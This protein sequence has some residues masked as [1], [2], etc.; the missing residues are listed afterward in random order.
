MRWL[1]VL[2]IAGMYFIVTSTQSLAVSPVSFPRSRAFGGE[3]IRISVSE[4]GEQGNGIS[5]RAQLSA[6]GRWVA[7]SSNSFNLTDED[8]SPVE[9]IFVHDLDT[10][11]LEILSTVAAGESQDGDST[12][13]RVS[14]DGGAVVWESAAGNL[15]AN[16]TNEARDIFLRQT[17]GAILRLSINGEGEEGNGESLSPDISA[18]GTV[19]VFESAADN[20]VPND[21][22]GVKDIFVV[23]LV[24]EGERAESTDL[25]SPF[26]F[27]EVLRISLSTNG[28][29]AD[30]DSSEARLS[31]DGRFVLFASAATNLVAEDTNGVTDIFV[32]EI[33]TGVTERVSVASDGAQADGHSSSGVMSADGRYVLFASFAD[34]F[35]TADSP[36]QDVFRYD[37]VTGMTELVSIS[38]LGA[39]NA[40]AMHPSVSAD[41]H[42]IVFASL[43]NNLVPNDTNGMYD[44]FYKDMRTGVVIRLSESADGTEGNR[45][46]LAPT[47]S[48]N[49]QIVAFGSEA[50]NLVAG[51]TNGLPDIFVVDVE[52]SLPPTLYLPFVG[53]S[54]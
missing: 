46:S 15:V 2:L 43:A 4:T 22:N 48:S 38:P 21:T 23:N 11:A 9:D 12:L 26:S 1:I 34:N 40:A 47:I 37:R 30:G 10:G 49:G 54:P 51:D 28:D 7:F 24:E 14:A 29:E 20:L 18:D 45:D 39:A 41:G 13:P 19:I 8:Q 32:Y 33:A 53:K 17:G 52:P 3:I 50:T 16:D 6:D 5:R 31:A 25:L 27:L 42:S 44:I 35:T 36:T